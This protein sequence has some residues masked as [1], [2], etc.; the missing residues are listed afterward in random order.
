MF[1]DLFEG[2]ST[3]NDHADA[4]FLHDAVDFGVNA[5]LGI[6][7]LS[8]DPEMNVEFSLILFYS[9]VKNSWLGLIL[10]NL[11]SNAIKY[12]PPGGLIKLSTNTNECVLTICI[13][14]EGAGMPEELLKS[15][16]NREPVKSTN[17]TLNEKG[18]GL[19]LMLVYEYAAL[20]NIVVRFEKRDEAGTKACI[21]IPRD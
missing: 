3:G 14:D 7:Y 18:T 2:H 17:G 19:G 6:Q 16:A 12:S 8:F 5:V 4:V 1:I 20:N 21:D 10:R 13:E 11:A 15:I 9:I